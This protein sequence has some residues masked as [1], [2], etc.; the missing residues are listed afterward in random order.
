MGFLVNPFRK[1]TVD[2]FTGVLVPIESAT[3]HPTVLA[4]Y[5]LLEKTRSADAQT[6]SSSTSEKQT[7]KDDARLGTTEESGVL[8]YGSSGCSPYSLEGLR[9]EVHED[10]AAGAH[11]T[12]YDCEW[13]RCSTD[14][15]LFS[16]RFL[17]TSLMAFY[18]G[19]RDAMT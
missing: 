9:M 8:H 5:A 7:S 4:K 14:F 10:V 12:T 11:S 2:S 3:R 17:S 19:N 1:E 15:N 13:E 18:P 6:A 16:L